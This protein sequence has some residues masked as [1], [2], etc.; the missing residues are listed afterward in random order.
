MMRFLLQLYPIHQS[1]IAPVY[2]L[3][4]MDFCRQRTIQIER[5]FY[6]GEATVYVM[7]I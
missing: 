2:P 1:P 3:L 7:N 4:Q 5:A 6:W